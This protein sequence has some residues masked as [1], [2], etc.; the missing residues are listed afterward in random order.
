MGQRRHSLATRQKMSRAHMG[1]QTSTETREKIRQARRGWDPSPETRDRMRQGQLGNKLTP[2]HRRN[3]SN[4]LAGK[5][6][7]RKLT[8][9]HRAKLRDAARRRSRTSAGRERLRKMRLNQEPQRISSLE[10]ILEAE[11]RKRRLRFEMH[12][13]MFGR[14]LPDFV[15]A[16]VNLIVQADGDYW[17][18]QRKPDQDAR[19]NN[20]AHA[21]GWTVWRFAETEIHM[22]AEACGRA[23]ARFVRSH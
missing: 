15:F 1:H 8:P 11:F 12:V 23:V 13:P 5:T 3:I 9:E 2:E 14:F 17:H 4:G 22:H 19:F 6:K 7:G 16:D 18:R 10:R 21:E 20:K